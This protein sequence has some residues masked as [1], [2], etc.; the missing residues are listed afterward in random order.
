VPKSFHQKITNPNCKHIKAAQK[1]FAQK[2]A[3]KIL[4]K[5][6]PGNWSNSSYLGFLVVLAL[7]P[8]AAQ[9]VQTG[10]AA[11]AISNIFVNTGTTYHGHL[12]AQQLKCE[13]L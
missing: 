5:L 4:A 1:T 6:T 13:T 12:A 8:W 10:R 3:H 2:A 7:S 11:V 9:G